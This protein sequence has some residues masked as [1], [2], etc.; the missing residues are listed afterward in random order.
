VVKQQ[1]Y[2]PVKRKG[3]L[4][5]SSGAPL[6]STLVAVGAAVL[7]SMNLGGFFMV[8][9]SM[10][11]VPMSYVSIMARCFMIAFFMMLGCFAVVLG[12][13]FQMFGGFVVVFNTFWHDLSPIVKDNPTGT[14]RVQ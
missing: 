5:S 8:M 1:F 2:Y 6:P 13:K 10:K 11:M 7:I 3:A 9:S 12:G 4:S 14:P